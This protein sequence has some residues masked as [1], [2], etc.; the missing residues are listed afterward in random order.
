MVPLKLK[1]HGEYPGSQGGMKKIIHILVGDAKI[2]V[3]LVANEWIIMPF[4]LQGIDGERV[5]YQT[6]SSHRK[7]ASVT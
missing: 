1:K 2:L 7:P 6:N 3:V 4:F 5:P